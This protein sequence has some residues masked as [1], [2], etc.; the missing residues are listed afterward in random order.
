MKKILLITD[1]EEYSDNGTISTLFDNYLKE[2]FDVHIVFLT[3]YKDSFQVKNDD[4]FIVPIEYENEVID[5]LDEK[6]IDISA[7]SLVMVRNKKDILKHVL[8]AKDKY[9]YKTAYRTSYPKAYHQL[10]L[11]DKDTISGW[12][13]SKIYQ[14]KIAERDRLANQCDLFLPTS[15]EVREVFYPNIKIESFP[16]FPGLNPDKLN[17][18]IACQDEIKK[19]IYIGRMDQVREFNVV[20]DAFSKLKSNNWELTI[21][22]RD[23]SY[24][25]KLLKSYPNIINKI[26]LTSAH[27]LE[28]LR[29]QVNKHDVGLALNPNIP[30][31]NTSVAD[32]VMDYYSCSVPTLMTSNEKNH[33][34]FADNEALFCDFERSSI[35]KKLDEVIKM[36]PEELSEIGNNGQKQLLNRRRNYKLLAKELSDKLNE[37]IS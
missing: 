29:N 7:Y 34:I 36:T 24:V 13:K 22:I 19:F 17:D 32:K 2:Y 23:K 20:L 30:L 28:E 9:G 35:V 1:Q 10:E 14:S 8:K 33:S 6:G 11:L 26:T 31:F 12:I 3:K 4:H 21:S 15:V 5:Y 27:D 16:V 25:I 18:H 37:I